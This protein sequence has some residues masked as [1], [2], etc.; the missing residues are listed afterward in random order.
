MNELNKAINHKKAFFKES[1]FLFALSMALKGI[2]FMH[3]KQARTD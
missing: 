3:S 1:A 2:F